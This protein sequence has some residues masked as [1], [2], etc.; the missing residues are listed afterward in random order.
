MK[1]HPILVKN[2]KCKSMTAHNSEELLKINL[3][4]FKK[5][6]KKKLAMSAKA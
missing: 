6:E 5:I 4:S 2:R 1:N 3:Y